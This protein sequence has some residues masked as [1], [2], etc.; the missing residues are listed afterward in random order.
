[1]I[2]LG[3]GNTRTYLVDAMALDGVYKIGQME[4]AFLEGPKNTF[5]HINGT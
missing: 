1:M 3:L 5:E 4:G 2:S